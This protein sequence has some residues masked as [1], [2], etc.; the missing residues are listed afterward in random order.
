MERVGLATLYE[1]HRRSPQQK[2]SVPFSGRLEPQSRARYLNIWKQ[3]IGYL[4]RTQT[5]PEDS[6]PSPDILTEEQA[7]AYDELE[8]YLRCLLRKQKSPFPQTMLREVDQRCLRLLISLLDHEIPNS[9]YDS[10]LIGALS[11]LGLR[12]STQNL[13]WLRPHEYTSI[14]SAIIKF[15]RL[16]VLQQSYEECR[17]I[18]NPGTP[19]EKETAPGLFDAVRSRTTRFMTIFSSETKPTPMDWILETR[20]YGSTI[21]STTALV[22]DVQWTGEQV[23][24]GQVSFAIPR[25]LDF[26][27]TLTLELQRTMRKLLLV[28]EEEEEEGGEEEGD[29]CTIPALNL[30]TLEDDA[31]NPSLDYTFLTDVRNQSQLGQPDW[32]LTRILESPAL[33]TRWLD[34]QDLRLMRQG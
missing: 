25:F 19:E 8:D 11:V 30:A 33:R 4:F 27:Q 29:I 23:R 3:V 28:E 31:G 24:F 12:S 15:G 22:A 5:W 2:A 32:I 6:Y 20:A 26:V 9:P 21:S 16:F 10:I 14:Y 34:G 13:E 7:D 18:L 1:L 17:Q